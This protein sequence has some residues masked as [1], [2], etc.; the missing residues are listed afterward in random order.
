VLSRPLAWRVID[1]LI[2]LMMA[3]IALQL[4]LNGSL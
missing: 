3:A 1:G 4:A 2:G